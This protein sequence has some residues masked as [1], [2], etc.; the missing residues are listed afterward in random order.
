MVEQ[1][2]EGTYRVEVRNSAGVAF[3]E[4]TLT[5]EPLPPIVAPRLAIA[6]VSTELFRLSLEG[7]PG[8][9]YLIQESTT[10]QSWRDLIRFVGRSEP[11]Q[12]AVPYHP[13]SGA[14]VFRGVVEPNSN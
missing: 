13:E 9:E 1:D 14:T 2:D 6:P 10:L 3:G 8:R 11:F 7:E 12:I 4:A 5:V